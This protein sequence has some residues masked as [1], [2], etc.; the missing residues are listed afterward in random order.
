M[1][2]DREKGLKWMDK[3]M[4]YKDR[5]VSLEAENSDLRRALA[6]KALKTTFE[7][8]LQLLRKTNEIDKLTAIL[9][10]YKDR[11]KELK[12]DNRELRNKSK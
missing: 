12:E 5:L 8:E 3:A 2:S 4:E 9:E 10:E 1:S 7:V 6:D 11:V